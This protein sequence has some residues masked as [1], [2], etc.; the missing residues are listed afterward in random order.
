MT[1]NL[2]LGVGSHQADESGST[3]SKLFNQ[4]GLW[5]FP[6]GPLV[7]NRPANA[8]DTDAIPGPES[9]HR[10]ATKPVRHNC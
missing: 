5:G 8:R 1:E 9:T 3:V 10:G 2:G 6:G 7:K 4:N